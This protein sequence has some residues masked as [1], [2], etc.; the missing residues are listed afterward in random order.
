MNNISLLKK[1]QINIIL[2]FLLVNNSYKFI[3]YFR[4]TSGNINFEFYYNNYLCK[5]LILNDGQ[6]CRKEILNDYNFFYHVKKIRPNINLSIDIKKSSI[7]NLLLIIAI[8]PFLKYNSTIHYKINNKNIYLL[9]KNLFNYKR[10]KQGNIIIDINDLE[11]IKN[12]FDI[13]LNYKWELLPKK[14][15]LDSIRYIINNYYNDYC[16]QIFDTLLNKNYKYQIQNNI[17][18]MSQASFEKLISK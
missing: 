7:E 17:N 5:F 18:Y 16:S 10:I 15:V 12:Q 9:F 3:N 13:L 8:V 11:I 14:E 6:S 2:F 1:I 4:E